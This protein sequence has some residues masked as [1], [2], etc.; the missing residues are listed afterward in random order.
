[1][2]RNVS[3]PLA[4]VGRQAIFDR[5][6]RVRAYELLYRDSFEN[7]ARF[8][9]VTQAAAATLVNAFVEIGLDELAGELPVY[10][11]LTA[12]FLTGRYRLPFG[13]ERLVLEVLESVEVTPELVAALRGLRAKG[14]RVALD[15][16]VLEERTRPL[17]EVADVIKVDVLGQSREAIAAAYEALRPSGA[18]LLAEKVS[19]R[20]ELEFVRDL[21]FELFQGFFLEVPTI[22]AKRR[23]PHQRATL[24]QLLAKLC[25]AA[26]LRE[27][28]PL[29]AMDVGLTVRL[30][31]LARSAAVAR[32]APIA[33]MGQ[34]LR[35]L[36]TQ[37]VA[38]LVVLV[39]ASG[40]DDK[41]AELVS[42]AVIRA[43]TCA[44]IGRRTGLPA[45]VL[46]TA[47]LL[48]LLDAILDQ[49][50]DVLLAEL[51]V[52]PAI[53]E[54]LATHTT[55]LGRVVVA[56]RA[57]DRGDAE[58]VLAAGIAPEIVA[59]AWREAVSWT[60]ALIATVG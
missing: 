45:D 23:L 8:S 31:K 34:A 22:A 3:A 38:A 30:L 11:N 16:F 58:G 4:F 28:E 54:A 46:F 2:H 5:D 60:R 36:G 13:P 43:Q 27:L 1:M 57:Q 55:P 29:L 47:G 50:L 17:L 15:D 12:E 41:P 42:Q 40:F 49:P 39:L 25:A 37:Q 14:Y 53:V 7:R 9:D 10:A 52:T 19:T 33:T 59:A 18:Q 26:D 24:L 21:G 6:L 51:P 32:G 35:R 44:L 20:D 48:S 56:A